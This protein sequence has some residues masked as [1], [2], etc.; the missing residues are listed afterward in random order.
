MSTVKII[1]FYSVKNFHQ[2]FN[3]SLL[4]I[5]AQFSEKIIYKLPKTYSNSIEDIFEN[6][7]ISVTSKIEL[8]KILTFEKNTKKGALFRHILGFFICIYEYLINN[9]ELLIYNYT[10]YFS[11]PIILMIN[12]FFR[13]KVIFTMHGELRLIEENPKWYKTSRLFKYIINLSLR[14]LFHKSN[15]YILIL[16][17]SIR[18]NLEKVY[19]GIANNIISICHPR[20]DK[21]SCSLQKPKKSYPRSKKLII[22]TVGVM[23][24]YK[25]IDN[26]IYLADN[27]KD[28]IRQDGVEIRSI[29]KVSGINPIDY[30]LITWIG[31]SNGL[32]RQ[33]FVDNINELDFIL[34]LYSNNYKYFASGA[35]LDSLECEKPIISL[36]NDYFNYILKGINI[37]YVMPDM[38]S[39]IELIRKIISSQDKIN[40][41]YDFDEFANRTS[42]SSIGI[43]MKSQLEEKSLI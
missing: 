37:G 25:G 36:C 13:K 2:I 11:L 18:D 41:H 21:N 20:L 35:I 3:A 42:I 38:A 33:E 39:I 17:D 26:L 9:K 27:L 14:R 40:H 30:P 23:N 4:C 24:K 32:S 34:Y 16:G 8:K 5:C 15:S 43:Q 12:R 19:P 28:E 7:D 22:G 10:N 31:A 1:D 29:G 6:I